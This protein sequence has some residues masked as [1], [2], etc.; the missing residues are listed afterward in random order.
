VPQKCSSVELENLAG[1]LGLVNIWAYHCY[2]CNYTWLP[3]DFDLGWSEHFKLE[4]SK[5]IQSGQE[6]FAQTTSQVMCKM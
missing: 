1:E 4:R 2:R 3:R 5:W 6:P